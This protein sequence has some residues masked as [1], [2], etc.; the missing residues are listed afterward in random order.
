MKPHIKPTHKMLIAWVDK[1]G[2]I[3]Y[4]SNMTKHQK[5]SLKAALHLGECK[6]V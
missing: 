3:K 2:K 1:K 6:N 5:Y 4:M